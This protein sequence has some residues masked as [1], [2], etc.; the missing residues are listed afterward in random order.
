MQNQLLLG[1]I[2]KLLELIVL[3]V[4]HIYKQKKDVIYNNPNVIEDAL[5]GK[6]LTIGEGG[7]DEVGELSLKNFKDVIKKLLGGVL[8][9]LPFVVAG[10]IILGIVLL[11]DSGKTGRDFGVANIITQDNSRN[12]W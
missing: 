10:G 6:R 2:K 9:M 8:W 3:R 5:N 12:N 7:N 11:L 4:F 1:L